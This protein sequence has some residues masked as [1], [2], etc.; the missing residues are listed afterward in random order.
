MVITTNSVL[1][2]EFFLG[3]EGFPAPCPPEVVEKLRGTFARIC[4]NEHF[5]TVTKGIY[6]CTWYYDT[7]NQEYVV[8]TETSHVYISRGSLEYLLDELD[9]LFCADVS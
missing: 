2:N 3:S 5:V 1:R 6:Y 4:V 9:E 7:I 8:K